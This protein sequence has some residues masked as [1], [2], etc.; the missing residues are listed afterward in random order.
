MQPPWHAVTSL[1]N[2]IV[3]TR[4]RAH[5]HTHTQFTSESALAQRHHA[6]QRL[7]LRFTVYGF[8]FRVWGFEALSSCIS[9]S[10]FGVLGFQDCESTTPARSLLLPR[11]HPPSHLSVM[12]HE[13]EFFEV[14]FFCLQRPLNRCKLMVEA[15]RLSRNG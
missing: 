1:R 2:G 6:S 14:L 10:T 8:G 15:F 3:I 11:L 9:S 7:G 4:A 13:S 12:G 5:T